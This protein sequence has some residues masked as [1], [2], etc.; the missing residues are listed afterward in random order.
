MAASS[1]SSVADEPI[2]VP[3]SD[4]TL[5][6]GEAAQQERRIAQDGI[7]F[8][9]EQFVEYYQADDP[10][11][12]LA[13]KM[14]DAAKP[15]IKKPQKQHQQRSTD[16]ELRLLKHRFLRWDAN[17]QNCLNKHELENVLIAHADTAAGRKNVK[18]KEILRK[19]DISHTGYI[20]WQ[21]FI[22]WMENRTP[23]APPFPRIREKALASVYGMAI[24]EIS[25]DLTADKSYD[26]WDDAGSMTPFVKIVDADI[27]SICL[28]STPEGNGAKCK[29]D[30]SKM[31]PGQRVIQPLQFDIPADD[32]TAVGVEVHL[33]RHIRGE[34][35]IAAGKLLL[36]SVVKEFS[37]NDIGRGTVKVEL[38]QEDGSSKGAYIKTPK[39]AAQAIGSVTM[40]LEQCE[41]DGLGIGLTPWAKLMVARWKSGGLPQ[42]TFERALRALEVLARVPDSA[43]QAAV[44]EQ[45]DKLATR[46]IQDYDK[47]DTDRATQ[48]LANLSQWFNK[49]ERAAPK[50]ARHGEPKSLAHIRIKVVSQ[51][52]KA[53]LKSEAPHLMKEA[54]RF[55]DTMGAKC[56]DIAEVEKLLRKRMEF[57][58]DTKLDML[59]S[60]SDADSLQRQPKEFGLEL[61]TDV[62][63]L[64]H[65][66][67][68]L[69]WRVRDE[70]AGRVLAI[71]RGSSVKLHYPKVTYE[72]LA[73]ETLV[74][75]DT[76]PLSVQKLLEKTICFR[77]EKEASQQTIQE[78][79]AS[80]KRDMEALIG[81]FDVVAIPV[82]AEYDKSFNPLPVG[83]KVSFFGEDP[84]APV[85]GEGWFWVLHAAAVNIGE[86]EH[87]EDFE[88]YAVATTKGMKPT[89]LNEDKYV[90]DMSALWRQ[91]LAAAAHLGLEDYV[92]FPF[93]M[94]A[95]LRNLHRIDHS[96]SDEVKMRRLRLRVCQGL[97]DAAAEICTNCTPPM[98]LHICL[99]DCNLESRVNHNCFMEAAGEKAKAVPA[100]RSLIKFHR[101]CDALELAHELSCRGKENGNEVRKVG[102]LNGANN[103]LLGNHWFSKGARQ[104]I[105]ENLH[106]RS[107]PMCVISLLINMATEPQKRS[108]QELAANVELLGGRVVE[109][110]PPPRPDCEANAPKKVS[111]PGVEIVGV[112]RDGCLPRLS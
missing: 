102:L 107:S 37:V 104:A 18:V 16:E 49:L 8:T 101:N 10:S 68:T 3:A 108:V 25:L 66:E 29:F 94:G 44:E 76:L 1:G 71:L 82:R 62:Q 54:L 2:V 31:K 79:I 106:R 20:D 93:G 55:N 75:H 105:D 39:P 109:L 5:V 100:L 30:L 59:L 47:F 57:P 73:V 17:G 11:N 42:L 22:S 96:Y 97:F 77:G 78:A 90:A 50:P 7:A 24:K 81:R 67:D 32:H 12:A 35:A 91:G 41:V 112:S 92:A 69:R 14:W 13:K 19:L 99:V 63:T 33:A 110:L 95:F 46:E 21:D 28:C 9:Y 83:G 45:I 103:K 38:F 72:K 74:T 84:A 43:L 87:A 6:Q 36:E 34:K 48:V 56:K 27:T 64:P 53:S 26:W 85:G 4:C 15:E 86:T 52:L 61:V 111:V 40:T 80:R 88:A 65:I 58:E 60:V 51:V 70:T 89:Q 98:R 23:N